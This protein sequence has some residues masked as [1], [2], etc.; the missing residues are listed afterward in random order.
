[1]QSEGLGESVWCLTDIEVS[2]VK[3][4]VCDS[5]KKGIGITK[6]AIIIKISI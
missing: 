3:T 4:E 2:K 6:A 1:M 5:R